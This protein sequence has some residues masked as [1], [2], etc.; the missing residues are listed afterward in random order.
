ECEV[1]GREAEPDRSRDTAGSWIDPLGRPVRSP[2][3]DARAPCGKRQWLRSQKHIG[4]HPT[5]GVDGSDGVRPHPDGGP[6]AAEREH[7]G[8]RD[9]ER[10]GQGPSAGNDQCP[11]ARSARS[12]MSTRWRGD[13][14]GPE[15]SILSEDGCLELPQLRP[16]LDP[17]IGHEA[18]PCVSVRAEGIRLAAGPVERKHQLSA[19]RLVVRI[20]PDE[21]LELG[22]QVAVSTEG[23]VRIDARSERGTPELLQAHAFRLR[24]LGSDEVR[25]RRPS[26]ERE[27]LLE[28][29]RRTP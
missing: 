10:R 29:S 14:S 18:T 5:V 26:P 1:G 27:R 28:G 20:L 23:E 16:G 8:E 24:E 6:P 21:T 11:A 3:P 13:L 2:D 19:E 15:Y 25:E 4:D 17:E 12:A 22:D 7:Q 9:A